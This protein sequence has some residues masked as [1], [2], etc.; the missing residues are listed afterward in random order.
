MEEDL[1]GVRERENYDH[2][3]CK[4][5]IFVLENRDSQY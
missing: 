4:E 1:V 3:I 2:K 5:N